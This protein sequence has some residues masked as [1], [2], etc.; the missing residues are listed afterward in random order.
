MTCKLLSALKLDVFRDTNY[1]INKKR[2]PL[3][4]FQLL[5]NTSREI[6]RFVSTFH[7]TVSVMERMHHKTKKKQIKLY[8]AHKSSSSNE[9]MK[10]IQRRKLI[11]NLPR[12]NDRAQWRLRAFG[13]TLIK[14]QRVPQLPDASGSILLRLT[15]TRITYNDFNA[16]S[17]R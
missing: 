7:K 12:W 11:I 10:A 14:S 9:I 15:K 16:A 8:F 2:S 6:F 5:S 17:M 13:G 1:N 4:S 3:A